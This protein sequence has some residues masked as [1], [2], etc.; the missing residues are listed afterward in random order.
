MS[1]TKDYPSCQRRDDTCGTSGQEGRA[2]KGL[3][4]TLQALVHQNTVEGL[5]FLELAG[6]PCVPSITVF[7]LDSLLDTLLEENLDVLIVL[8][9]SQ[10]AECFVIDSV[11]H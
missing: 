2:L 9:N 4:H 5:S 11:A 8:I 7:F 6:M 1:L 10:K 3:W